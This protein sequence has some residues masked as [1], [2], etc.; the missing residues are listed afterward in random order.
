MHRHRR[1]RLSSDVIAKGMQGIDLLGVNH[2]CFQQ[3]N[4]VF[5]NSEFDC[6]SKFWEVDP[7]YGGSI[8]EG[9]NGDI[10]LVATDQW[11]SL[12]QL[13]K[14]PI[15]AG[16]YHME[17]T[18]TDITGNGKYSYRTSDGIWTNAFKYTASGTYKADIVTNKAITAIDVGAD[19]D[20]DAII[21]F[22][23]IICTRS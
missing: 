6:G 18:I 7:N 15:P 9:N 12:T 23:S 19:D 1:R 16:S 21:K 3:S 10:T 20:T 22:D 5:L 2:N 13:D 14:F 11:S 8:S 17:V 4:E